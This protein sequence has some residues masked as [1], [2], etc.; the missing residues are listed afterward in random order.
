LHAGYSVKDVNKYQA[1]H[2]KGAAAKKPKAKPVGKP[3]VKKAPAP[4]APAKPIYDGAIPDKSE[5]AAEELADAQAQQ[6]AD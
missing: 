2:K 5:N 3:V 4:I 1:T 6:K